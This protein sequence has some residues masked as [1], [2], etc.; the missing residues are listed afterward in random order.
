M[1]PVQSAWPPSW[2][3]LSR[4]GFSK[5]SGERRGEERE[6]KRKEEKERNGASNQPPIIALV[7]LHEE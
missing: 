6:K 5:Q 7:K 2:R 3:V 1:P 4:I